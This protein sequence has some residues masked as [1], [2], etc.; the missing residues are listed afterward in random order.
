MCLCSKLYTNLFI[1][2]FCGDIGRCP[3]LGSE[4]ITFTKRPNDISRKQCNLLNKHGNLLSFMESYKNIDILY[5]SETGTSLNS[6]TITTME[7]NIPAYSFEKLNRKNGH[8][9][10]A[11][12]Y[13]HEKLSWWRRTDLEDSH[14]ECAWIEI[15]MKKSEDFLITTLHCPPDSSK[16]LPSDFNNIFNDN[17]RNACNESKEIIISGDVNVH[18]SKDQW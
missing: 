12:I 8:G 15:C 13:I 3:G 7:Y 5:L 1:L 10:W 2:L 17:L 6:Y 18:F 9:G 14:L 11:A 4:C 16:F